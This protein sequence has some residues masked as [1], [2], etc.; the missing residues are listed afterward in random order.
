MHFCQLQVKTIGPLLHLK[1]RHSQSASIAKGIITAPQY[2]LKQSYSRSGPM[3][4]IPMQDVVILPL[5]LPLGFVSK[6]KKKIKKKEKL[7]L[8]II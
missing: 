2:C 8:N 7:T 3:N 6:K 4:N 5:G 1:L